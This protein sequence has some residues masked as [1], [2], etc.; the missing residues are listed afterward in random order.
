MANWKYRLELKDLWD[1][2]ESGELT[3]E[4]LGKE[5]ARRLRELHLPPKFS[6]LS[7]VLVNRF[8]CVKDVDEFD[9]IL[10]GLYDLGDTS[11]P[12]PNGEIQR[13]LKLI[14]VNTL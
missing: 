8:E 14:W 10:E 11:L 9:G 5:V 13:K 12:T 7:E 3:I 1:N 6:Y 4:N 2:F